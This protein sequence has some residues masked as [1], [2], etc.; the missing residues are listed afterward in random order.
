MQAKQISEM[1]QK[2]MN[3]ATETQVGGDHYKDMGI[4]PAEYV[5]RNKIP[6]LEGSV[7]YYVTRWRKKNGIEDLKK[8]RHTL[9]LIIEMETRPTARLPHMPLVIDSTVDEIKGE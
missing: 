4:Q 6:Y 7:I 1:G 5:H 8:A 2:P 9:D 3:S